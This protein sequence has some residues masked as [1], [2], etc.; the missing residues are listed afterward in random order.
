MIELLDDLTVLEER[1]DPFCM[2]VMIH[3]R[4]STPRSAGSRML[5]LGDGSIRGTVGGGKMEAEAIAAAVDVLKTGKSRILDFEFSGEDAASLDMICGGSA[6]ILLEPVVSHSSSLRNVMHALKSQ[7]SRGWMITEIQSTGEVQ[8]RFVDQIPASLLPDD[9]SAVPGDIS[10]RPFLTIENDQLVFVDPLIPPS[11][12]LVFGAGHVSRSL[13]AV[14]HITG[15]SVSVIDDRADFANRERFPDS[16]EVLVVDP[17]AAYFEQH[18][19]TNSDMI[20]IVTRGHLADQEVL[21]RALQTNAGYIGMI[22][23]RRKRELIYRSL[24]EK[25]FGEDQIARIS[26]PI[27]LSIGAETPEEIAVSITAELI[28][29]RAVMRAG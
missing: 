13:A 7:K 22:G 6:R 20:V 9:L 24:R 27:G 15:F 21:E 4:G 16:D 23:S 1:G 29:K 17:I 26:S 5:V 14:A 12:V 11:R 10:Q 19:V 2:V 3:S 25:G 28:Q 8:N 18:A